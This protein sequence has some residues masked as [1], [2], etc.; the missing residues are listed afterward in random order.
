MKAGKL[1]RLLLT[2]LVCSFVIYGSVF[3]A[4]GDAVSAITGG[5]PIPD[6]VRQELVAHYRLNDPF[7][8]RYFSWLG[9][10][11]QGDFGQSFVSRQPALDLLLARLPVT[12]ALVGY[13][14]L[15]IIL[16]G[17]PLGVFAATRGGAADT[18]T[19]VITGAV[20]AVPA[21]VASVALLVVFAVNLRLFPSFGAGKGFWDGLY[22]LTLPAIALALPS[23]SYVARVTRSAVRAETS[24]EYVEAALSRGLSRSHVIR[25]HILRN[26]LLPIVTTVGVTIS[27]LIAGT[28][29]VEQMF[30]ISGVGRLLVQSVAAK[31]AAVVQ[32]VSMFMVFSFVVLNAAVDALYPL[33]DP[34]IRG[35]NR[36]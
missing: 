35:A 5:R 20:V 30:S 9:G 23:A 28:V 12:M 31:D 29:V 8:I 25:V 36:Q 2:L 27:G 15:M 19:V 21:F 16:V 18:L 22:H 32:A 34:R 1:L 6:S 24:R 10:A 26:A 4:P 3:L 13:A 33:L 11:L 17:V 7:L 14:S